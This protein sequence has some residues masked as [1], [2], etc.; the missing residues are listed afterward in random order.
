MASIR[1]KRKSTSKKPRSAKK[2]S[3]KTAKKP[4][5]LKHSVASKSQKA[6]T[7]AS[8]KKPVRKAAKK[9]KK[10]KA[11]KKLRRKPVKKAVKSTKARKKPVKKARKKLSKKAKRVTKRAGKRKATKKPVKASGKKTVKAKT[12]AV[13]KRSSKVNKKQLKLLKDKHVQ[14]LV[15]DLAGERSLKVI[16][17]VKHPM[18]DEQIANSAGVKVSEVRAVLN[19]LHSAGLTTYERT[20]DKETGWYSYTW[21]LALHNAAEIID[22]KKA[23]EAEATRIAKEAEEVT[24][25]F[26]CPSCF[27]RTGEQHVFDQAADMEFKCPNCSELLKYVDKK[28]DGSVELL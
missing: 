17:E 10:P 14:G 16:G 19:K 4:K 12:A 24:E 20:K 11:A 9:V 23:A 27:K 8:K 15:V 6:K 3:R 21:D 1:K 7:K 13:P 28:K 2:N 5:K 25:Y 22:A 26:A 18:S